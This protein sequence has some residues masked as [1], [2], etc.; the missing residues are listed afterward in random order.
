MWSQ[1]ATTSRRPERRDHLHFATAGSYCANAADSRGLAAGGEQYHRG[2]S[3]TS[4]SIASIDERIET[5][6]G[7]RVLFDTDLAT[8]YG[9]TTG[10][11]IQ[12]VVRNPSRFPD[13]FVFRLT[14]Q[15]VARLR[16]QFVISKKRGRG[17]RR[18]APYAFTEQG[19]AML[20]SVLR[21]PVSRRFAGWLRHRQI[22]V[23]A[24]LVSCRSSD[25]TTLRSQI[26]T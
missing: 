2:V 18:Y 6:R 11:L 21:S 5:I 26:V 1:I 24:R 17:G 3:R 13:D 7:H 4:P 25:V 23:N 16:S 22:P 19:V 15:E 9:V 12:A 20:S 8:L 14:H 10:A